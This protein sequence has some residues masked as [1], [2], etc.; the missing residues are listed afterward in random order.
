MDD[1]ETEELGIFIKGTDVSTTQVVLSLPLPAQGSELLFWDSRPLMPI[2]PLAPVA[3]GQLRDSRGCEPAPQLPVQPLPAPLPGAQAG[4][5]QCCILRQAH[6][7]C[8]HGPAHT[9]LGDQVSD[10]PQGS[11]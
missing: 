1:G 5:S 9:T 6:P 10:N 4:A 3:S 11:L 7:L 8:I 2:C